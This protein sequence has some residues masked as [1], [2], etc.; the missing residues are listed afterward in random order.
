MSYVL[1]GVKNQTISPETR[2]RVHAAVAELGYIPNRSARALKEGATRIVLLDLYGL[3]VGSSFDGFMAGLDAEFSAKGLVLLV[4]YGHESTQSITDVALEVAA[5]TLI[6]AQSLDSASLSALKTGNVNVN[7]GWPAPGGG[8]QL[9]YLANKGHRH[10]AY[11]LPGDLRLEQMGRLRFQDTAEAARALGIPPLSAFAISDSD[12]EITARRLREA[13]DADPAITAV[14]AYNDD[15]A[16]RVLT[17][18]RR[19]GLSAPHDLAVIGVDDDP[20]A[21]LWQ[22]A[23]TTVRFDLEALGR[24]WARHILGEPLDQEALEGTIVAR[25]SA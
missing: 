25:D 5:H 21:S 1:N 10:I 23:V 7:H 17:A 3:P 2:Q 13:L 20:H 6:S 16:F 9:G 15:V 12:I 8:V 18:M 22:P 4:H 19:L 24:S 11:A 14:A